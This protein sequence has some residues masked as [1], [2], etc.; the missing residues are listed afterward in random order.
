MKYCILRTSKLTSFGSIAS[1]A[2]HTFRELDTPNADAGRTHLN[3]TVGAKSSL[4]VCAAVRPKLPE[5]RRR[6]AV[7]CIEYLITASP[8]WLREITA[9]TQT[10]YFNDALGWLASVHGRG[11]IVCANL[12]LDE[13]SPHLVAYVVPLCAD[14]RLS[15]KEFLGGRAKLSQLQ[16]D[17]FQSVGKPA[18]L[19]RGIEGSR[20]NHS[21]NK[22]YNAAI[23]ANPSLLPPELPSVSLVDR[24]TGRATQLRRA[25]SEQLHAHLGLVES[26][27]NAAVLSYR[28]R[29]GQADA[30]SRIRDELARLQASRDKARLLADEARK[31]NSELTAEKVRFQSEV[32]A[33]TS[34]L[35]AS[36]KDRTR[37]WTALQKAGSE[38]RALECQP[39]ESSSDHASFGP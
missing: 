19:I 11:N 3:Q 36:T 26:A 37:L 29:R 2:R 23:A 5:R 21:T 15:A 16:T 35:A 22:Q 24:L 7:L 14:G 6:D 13:T 12:Q 28:S 20:A 33:L 39:E 17:F 38:D 25:Y 30:L 8:E 9:D 1:S 34:E 27:R 4:A 31:A 10:K 18:G 32:A